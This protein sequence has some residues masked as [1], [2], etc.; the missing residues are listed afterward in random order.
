MEWNSIVASV[1]VSSVFSLALFFL[2]QR[3]I[4]REV[5]ADRRNERRHQAVL[6]ALEATDAA[7]GA[8]AKSS[9]GWKNAPPAYEERK[10]RLDT[11][12]AALAG[13]IEDS[14]RMPV[15]ALYKSLDAEAPGYE[16]GAPVGRLKE[17]RDALVALLD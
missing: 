12:V 1:I 14:E 5:L 2:Q 16:A 3:H 7:I 11:A 17:L 6:A 8:F 10:A 15:E 9:H 4:R 13:R